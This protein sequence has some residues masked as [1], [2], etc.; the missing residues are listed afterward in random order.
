M[1]RANFNGIL[2]GL[3]LIALALGMAFYFFCRINPPL[4]FRFWM[5]HG[6]IY[7]CGALRSLSSLPSGLHAFGFTCLLGACWGGTRLALLSSAIFWFASNG[8]WE[9]ACDVDFPW[10]QLRMHVVE[11]LFMRPGLVHACTA[12]WMDVFSA[13]VGAALPIFLHS[14]ICSNS[15]GTIFNQ[16]KRS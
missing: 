15:E 8:L 16:P 6:D 7:N 2:W 3:G 1:S 9:W 14:A 5:S 11:W 13:A 12:D 4:F 10:P